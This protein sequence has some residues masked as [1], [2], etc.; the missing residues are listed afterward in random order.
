[1]YIEGKSQ[2]EKNPVITVSGFER[3][4]FEGY[5]RIVEELKQRVTKRPFVMVVD[6]YPG[7]NDHEV[8]E[9]LSRL[10]ADR[11]ILT[12]ELFKKEATILE[13]LKYQLT[14]DRVFGKLYGGRNPGFYG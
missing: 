12:A 14:D 5:D 7:V 11:L 10:G 4:V 2:Y 13:Q 3:E 9:A 1:M 6:C 8:L